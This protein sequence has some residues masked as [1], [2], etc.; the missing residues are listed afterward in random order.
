MKIGL[1][2][3]LC[4]LELEVFLNILEQTARQKDVRIKRNQVGEINKTHGKLFKQ[5]LLESNNFQH[6]APNDAESKPM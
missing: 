3:Y 6:S 2:R 4:F 1:K 5:Q